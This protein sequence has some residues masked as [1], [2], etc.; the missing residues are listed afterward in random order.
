MCFD[1]LYNFCLKRLILSKI[2]G[3]IITNIQTSSY[4][5]IVILFRF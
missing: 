3:N 1:F 5:V 4:K 2:Q